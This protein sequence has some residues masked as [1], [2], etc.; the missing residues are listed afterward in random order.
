MSENLNIVERIA[1]MI[2]AE[3]AY[4]MAFPGTN[5][6]ADPIPFTTRQKYFQADYELKAIHILKMLLSAGLATEEVREQLVAWEKHGWARL[7][8][9]IEPDAETAAL[10]DL[11]IREKYE[12]LRPDPVSQP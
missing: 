9:N 1:R 11:T 12:G 10:T 3:G 6:A 4:G 5:P 7:G 2:D 8:I